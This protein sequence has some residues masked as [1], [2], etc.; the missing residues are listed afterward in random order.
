[1]SNP[2]TND[3]GLTKD[4]MD[5]YF[6]DSSDIDNDELSIIEDNEEPSDIND[7]AELDGCI[8]S[9]DYGMSEEMAEYF[10]EDDEVSEQGT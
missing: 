5:E 10:S 7:N 2:D 3:L 9:E 4:E 6:S 8:A 1:M